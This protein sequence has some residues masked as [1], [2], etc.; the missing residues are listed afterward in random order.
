MKNNF[1][2]QGNLLL[3]HIDTADAI[4][5]GAAAGMSVAAGYD[6]AYHNDKYFEKYL[7]EYSNASEPPFYRLRAI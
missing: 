5:V 7:G 4:C 6:C 1:S 2:E 3:K